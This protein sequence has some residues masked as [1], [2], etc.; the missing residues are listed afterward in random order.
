MLGVILPGNVTVVRRTFAVLN[1][2][3]GNVAV[4]DSVLFVVCTVLLAAKASTSDLWSV[5]SSFSGPTTPN[6]AMHQTAR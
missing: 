1:A 6:T 4:V 2:A 5:T 3:N